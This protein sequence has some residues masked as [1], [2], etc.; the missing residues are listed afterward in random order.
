MHNA[1][2]GLFNLG[3]GEIILILF[4]LM[5]MGAGAVAVVLM[6]LWILA[7]QRNSPHVVPPVQPAIP[8]PPPPPRICPRCGIALPAD[9]PEGLCPRC[10]LGVGLAAHT[11]GPGEFGS[12]GTRVVQPPPAPSEIASHFPQ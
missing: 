8:M 3:G 7:K 6:A 10:V 11:D 9:A 2:L 4:M 1:M 5:L 12:H